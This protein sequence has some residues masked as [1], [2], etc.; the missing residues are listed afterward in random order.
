MIVR[1]ALVVFFIVHALA[2][3]AAQELPYDESA[4]ARVALAEG[5]AAASAREKPLM[6]VFGANWCPDCR[7]LDKAMHE[8]D[9]QDL[10]ERYFQLVK[11]DVGNW[12]KNLDVVKQFDNPIEGGIPSMVISDNDHNTLF[13][14]KGGQLA[15]ARTM[16]HS[17][18]LKFFEEL[19]KL[20]P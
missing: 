8:A 6:I 11:I 9:I 13:M 12:D 16:G 17:T 19:S 20:E 14:T 15:S 1:T 10:V 7:A 2:I 5:Y 3:S 18:L 4:D